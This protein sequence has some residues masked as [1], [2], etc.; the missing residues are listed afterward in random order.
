VSL[1]HAFSRTRATSDVPDQ[2]IGQSAAIR[3]IRASLEKVAATESN[4]L[5]TGETGTGK[6]LAARLIHSAGR[7]RQ[8]P[9]VSV[10]CAA[11]PD[12]LIE[13]ELFG[14]ER[15]AFTGAAVSRP[16]LLQ[17]AH[18]GTVFLDEIGDTSS[19]S[20]AKLLRAIESREI[21]P[22]GSRTRVAL[23]VRIIAATNQELES[24]VR[25]GRFRK[26]LFFRLNVVRIHLPPLRE[27]SVDVP[28][29]VVHYSQYFASRSAGQPHEYSDEALSCLQ[30]HSWP[31]NVRELKNFVESVFAFAARSRIEVTDLPRDLVNDLPATDRDLDGERKRVLGAL[32]EAR[33]NKSRAA[34]KLRCSRMTLYRRMARL[35]VGGDGS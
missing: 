33:W 11:I 2:F 21:V 5:I 32:L 23:D 26:D 24:A 19:V 8:R 10:N 29:L 4:V 12:T 14:Y 35:G 13:S 27:H 6:E 9:F 17:Q 22:L 16:G 7:R 15:G 25:Q 20:Q 3:E 28:S 1:G 31:G 34:R 30:R 18:G